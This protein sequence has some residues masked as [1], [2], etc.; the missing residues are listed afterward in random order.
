M[1]FGMLKNEKNCKLS[2]MYYVSLR[3]N[4]KNLQV[5]KR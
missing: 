4:Y 1:S 3:A 5:V 2:A